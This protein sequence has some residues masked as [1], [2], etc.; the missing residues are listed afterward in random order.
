MRQGI[1]TRYLGPTNTKGSRIKAIAR[2]RD[3]WGPEMSLTR[4]RSGGLSVEANHASAAKE[5][6]TK[7]GWSGLWIAGGMP[8]GDGNMYVCLGQALWDNATLMPYRTIGKEGEDWFY[9]PEKT[10]E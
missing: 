3:G 10:S 7:L 5:L 6:A 2:K 1:T 9:V 8:T 4:H